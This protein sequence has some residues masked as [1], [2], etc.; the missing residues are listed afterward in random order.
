MA[1]RALNQL[2]PGL[3]PRPLQIEPDVETFNVLMAACRLS[4]QPEGA[5]RAPCSLGP[6]CLASGCS[7][8]YGQDVRLA[9]LSPSENNR[10]ETKSQLCQTMGGLCVADGLSV[11]LDGQTTSESLVE[12]E[13]VGSR[14]R[15]MGWHGL[16]LRWQRGAGNIGRLQ[17]FLARIC[18]ALRPRSVYVR[19]ASEPRPAPSPVLQTTVYGQMRLQGLLPDIVTYTTLMAAKV[20]EEKFDQAV[21]RPRNGT[22]PRVPCQG[23]ELGATRIST[24]PGYRAGRK[25]GQTL[26]RHGQTHEQHGKP[27]PRSNVWPS[28]HGS[29]VP[30]WPG[31][32]P[33]CPDCH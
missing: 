11:F 33:T 29:P 1:T 2:H 17:R 21:R 26:T 23:W 25:S 18:P 16:K 3:S 28:G 20:D 14:C 6:L 10:D 15:E 7:S 9:C 5:V 32:T 30:I 19:A 12:R 4:G 27:F 31:T 13:Q 22:W 8:T 24:A